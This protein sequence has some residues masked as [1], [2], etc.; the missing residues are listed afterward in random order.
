MAFDSTICPEG[1]LCKIESVAAE[2]FFCVIAR[3]GVNCGVA[4][5]CQRRTDRTKGGAWRL[6]HEFTSDLLD[7]E[8]AFL[9]QLVASVFRRALNGVKMLQQNKGLAETSLDLLF[10]LNIRRKP[11]RK[12]TPP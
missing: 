10:I 11:I 4:Q 1:Q 6:K 3:T 2:V 7:D 5:S 8:L 12:L 9:I